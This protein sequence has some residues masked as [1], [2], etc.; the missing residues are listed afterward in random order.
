MIIDYVAELFDFLK[1]VE[2]Y[3]HVSIEVDAYPD[4]VYY[5]TCDGTKAQA[6]D[7]SRLMLEKYKHRLSVVGVSTTATQLH[8]PV[9]KLFC[10]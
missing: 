9:L 7:V 2:R 6:R 8:E 10:K 3:T 1:C 4:D 5:F